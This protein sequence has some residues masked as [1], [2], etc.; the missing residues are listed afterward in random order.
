VVGKAPSLPEVERALRAQQALLGPAAAELP[1]SPWGALP[2]PEEQL[3]EALG[4]LVDAV[5]DGLDRGVE[6]DRQALKLVVRLLA[7][8]FAERHPG[9]TVEVRVPPYAAVQCLEGPRHTRGTPPNVV[10]A[11]PLAWV[12]V[13]TGRA[14]WAELVRTG[15][16]RASGDRSD[17]SS[18]LPLPR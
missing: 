4:R 16:I 15:R 2:G 13:C 14:A 3:P 6:P 1:A 12:R 11:D 8:A 10:E 7:R 17:L 18:L 5:V 9:R